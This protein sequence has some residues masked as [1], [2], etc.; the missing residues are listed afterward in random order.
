M[1]SSPSCC[2]TCTCAL[3]IV[4]WRLLATADSWRSRVSQSGHVRLRAPTALGIL[5]CPAA[6]CLQPL[7]CSR[8]LMSEERRLQQDA[9]EAWLPV[10]GQ[11]FNPQPSR[12]RDGQAEADL[13]RFGSSHAQRQL[14]LA[15]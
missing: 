3:Q 4:C 13:R 12:R 2:S 1:V 6:A 10:E 5:L 9:S 14:A 8:R 11:D 15:L 7:L